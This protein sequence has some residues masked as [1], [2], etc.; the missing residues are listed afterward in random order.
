[1]KKKLFYFIILIII[2]VDIIITST[3]GLNVNLYYGEGDI[4]TFIQDSMDVSG[5]KEV[6]NEVFG[7]DNFIVQKIEFFNDSY[8]IKT[9]EATNDNLTDLCDKL[10]EKYSTELT[11]DTFIVNHVA[12]TRI[13]EI[14]KPYIIPTLMSIILIL[15]IYAV[16]FKGYKQMIILINNTVIVQVILYS[17]YAICRVK[18]NILSMPVAFSIF[19]FTTLFTTIY[20]LKNNFRK[21]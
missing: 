5:I 1:M 2:V 3:K 19:I 4:I 17:I 13:R 18:V 20:L 9:K 8:S 11:F 12:N 21:E 7:K 14:V 16:M 15:V 6:C 10:N